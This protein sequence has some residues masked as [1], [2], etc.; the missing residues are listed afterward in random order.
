MERRNKVIEHYHIDL[1]T[2][3]GTRMVVVCKENGC[4]IIDDDFGD[5]S[6]VM[7]KK[8]GS[9]ICVK[10]AVREAI[11]LLKKKYIGDIMYGAGCPPTE[12]I[13]EI[14]DEK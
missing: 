11:K 8:L 14:L 4:Y 13:D 9:F 10:D 12:M 2:N 6:G 7:G 1:L 5:I 3:K